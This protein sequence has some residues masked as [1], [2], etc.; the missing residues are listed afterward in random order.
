MFIQPVVITVKKDRSVKIAL[1]AR[2]LNIGILKD[3][4]Q[5][6][7]SGKLDGKGFR[8]HYWEARRRSTI[9]IT[10]HASH[11]WTNDFTPRNRKNNVTFR[12]SGEKRQVRITHSKLDITD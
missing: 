7:N 8:N 2:S 4:Y 10:G 1:D 12:S 3:N 11:V 5:M 9:H 6:P